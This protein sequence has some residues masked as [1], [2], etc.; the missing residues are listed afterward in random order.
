MTDVVTHQHRDVDKKT[1]PTTRRK[2]SKMAQE[3]GDQNNEE[4]LRK[5]F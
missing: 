4:D 5:Q 3:Q 1:L 2:S